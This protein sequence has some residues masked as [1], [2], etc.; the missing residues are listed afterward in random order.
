MIVTNVHVV[1]N[2]ANL[3]Y[4]DVILGADLDCKGR[5]EET[6]SKN[7]IRLVYGEYSKGLVKI[8]DGIYGALT[9]VP[10]ANGDSGLKMCDR[11]LVDIWT[12]DFG[13]GDKMYYTTTNICAD[14]AKCE[15]PAMTKTKGYKVQARC[16]AKG[17]KG[18]GSSEI[19]YPYLR[20]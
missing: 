20:I 16:L 2:R 10:P 17:P 11:K 1:V 13:T 6:R 3:A 9:F 8:S 14:P 12:D 4:A 5:F 19:L 7:T 15:D 18:K